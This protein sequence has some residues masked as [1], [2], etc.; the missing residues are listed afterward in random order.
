MQMG[1]MPRWLQTV[2]GLPLVLI[3]AGLLLTAASETIGNIVVLVGGLG[4]AGVALALWA[5]PG[6]FR[7]DKGLFGLGSRRS[8]QVM[9]A[10]MIVLGLSFVVTSALRL[11]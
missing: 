11:A 10:I 7:D 8:P 3:G 5:N 4:L 2:R 6:S 9:A 1:G